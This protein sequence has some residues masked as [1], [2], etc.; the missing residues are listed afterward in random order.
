[1]SDAAANAETSAGSLSQMSSLA[2]DEPSSLATDEPPTP[3]LRSHYHTGQV[4]S[5]HNFQP[6]DFFTYEQPSGIETVRN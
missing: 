1:M 4:N 2:T 5:M 3:Q 6:M